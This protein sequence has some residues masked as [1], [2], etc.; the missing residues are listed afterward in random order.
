MMTRLIVAMRMPVWHE[1][2]VDETFCQFI[3]MF[4]RVVCL[5]CNSGSLDCP[6][7]GLIP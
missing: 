2:G 4:E 5:K 3:Q 7:Q 6:Q 1:V